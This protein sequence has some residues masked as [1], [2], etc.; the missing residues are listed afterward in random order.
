MYTFSR[1][2]K[3]EKGITFKD[4]TEKLSAHY[5]EKIS[6]GT[7]VHLCVPRNKRRLSSKRYK[8]VANVKYQKP[9][10]GLISSLILIQSEVVRCTS[11]W[12][13]SKRH[14]LLLNRDNQAGF[15]LDSTYTH[16][17]MP[18][19]NV[20]S[21]TLTTHTYFLNKHKAQLQTTSYN[22]STTSE[23]CCG[24]VKASVV[25]EKNPSQ[26]AADLMML[27][28]IPELSLVFHKDQRLQ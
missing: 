3:K 20:D 28:E 11:A 15:R 23:V 13:N 10:K 18:S 17:S 5:G 22:F 7:V 9:R 27:D 26:H 25:H 21:P 14:I 12:A 1:D 6:Y 24:V 2:T 8:G 4:L 19:I 16:K